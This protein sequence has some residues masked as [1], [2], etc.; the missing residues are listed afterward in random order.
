VKPAQIDQIELAFGNMTTREVKQ[1]G[2]TFLWNSMSFNCR[3]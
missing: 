3:L 2:Q 1:A